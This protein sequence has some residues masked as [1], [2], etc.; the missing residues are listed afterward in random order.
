MSLLL[1]CSSSKISTTRRGSRGM[2]SRWEQRRSPSSGPSQCPYLLSEVFW[3][4]C[5][6]PCSSKCLEG[7]LTHVF[8]CHVSLQIFLSSCTGL[9]RMIRRVSKGFVDFAY[10]L[11]IKMISGSQGAH[12]SLGPPAFARL[13]CNNPE[14]DHS[15]FHW[16]YII[17]QN[18]AWRLVIHNYK[19]VVFIS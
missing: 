10:S 6:S 1:S 19:S 15:T 16:N 12:L 14:Y 18:T 2:G 17:M 3:E 7:Q 4:R 11:I 8:S 5:L 9:T 13:A